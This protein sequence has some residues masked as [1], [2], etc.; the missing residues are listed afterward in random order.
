MAPKVAKT[1]SAEKPP[2]PT[3][4]TGVCIED[5]VCAPMRGVYGRQGTNGA[6]TRWVPELSTCERTGHTPIRAMPAADEAVAFESAT[7]KE[8]LPG[9]A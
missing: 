4:M 9:P 8:G 5:G 3:T 2:P 6:Y 1:A 7:V